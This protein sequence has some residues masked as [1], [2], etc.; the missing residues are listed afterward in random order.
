MEYIL[1]IS[2]PE[3]LGV[4]DDL[5]NALEDEGARTEL[6][7]N[8]REWIWDFLTQDVPYTAIEVRVE[9]PPPS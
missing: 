2:L 6:Q 9:N 7:V 8:I 1:K 4:E 3:Y 5:S